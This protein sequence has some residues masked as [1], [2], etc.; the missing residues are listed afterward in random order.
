[1]L[2]PGL[3]TDI[4]LDTWGN[5]VVGANGDLE[6]IE[7]T[8]CLMQGVRHRLL[9]PL[10]GL[11]YDLTYGLDIRLFTHVDS[12]ALSR[13]EL[14]EGV[15]DQ[16][17]L[18]PRILRESISVTVITWDEKTVVLGISFAWIDGTTV[19][20]MVYYDLVAG[21]PT[22]IAFWDEINPESLVINETPD[23]DVDGVNDEFT[24]DATPRAG[25]LGVWL[26]GLLQNP[27]TDYTLA[28]DTITFTDP[29]LPGDKIRA[30]YIAE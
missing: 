27:A 26:N 23:G 25:T 13:W 24:L 18:E 30:C 22:P 2:Y 17:R 10:G 20:N 7:D 16:L 12:T 3:G 28:G 4:K 11:F 19:E 21:V 6:L 9:T 29:P 14:C 8:P 15:K 1:M 5:L